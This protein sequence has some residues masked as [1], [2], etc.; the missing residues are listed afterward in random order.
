M[1]DLDARDIPYYW[2]TTFFR[3]LLKKGVRHVVI[4]PGSRSTP[5]TM[6]AAAHPNLEKHVILDE[7]SAAFTALGIGKAT[8]YPAVLICTSGTA[9]ANYYPAVIEAR[10]SGVP[11]ILATADRPPHL[12]ATGANQAIDQ[13]KLF[14]SYPV[15]F[16]EAGEPRLDKEDLDRLVLLA[17]QAVGMAQQKRGPVHINFPFRKPLEPRPSF[18]A[19]IRG[20]N[21]SEPLTDQE[22]R[23]SKS[24]FTL[25]ETVRRAMSSA[26][27]PLIVVGPAAPGDHLESV[28]HLAEQLRA[29]VLSESTIAS[30]NTVGGFA[31]FLR[32][33]QLVHQLE[34]DLILRFGFQPTAKSIE[35]ALQSWRPSHHIHFASTAD[36]QDATCTQSTH[37]PW[38]GQPLAL[39]D[40]LKGAPSS[41]LKTWK[42]QERLFRS[43]YQKVMSRPSVLTDGH[44][45]QHLIT[46]CPEDLFIAVSNSFPARDIQLTG[47]D[48]TRY[49]LYLNRGASGIDGV[50]STALG[51]S[52][53]LR[54]PGM[55]LTGDLAFLHDTNALLNHN[56]AGADLA[57]V[58][59]NNSG[60][61]IFR[62][63]PIEQH[64]AYFDTYF[65]TPQAASIRQL[66]NAYSIPYHRVSSVDELRQF[67][68]EQWQQEQPGLSVVECL[69]DAEASMK[70]RRQLWDF[71]P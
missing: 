35:Q 37:L 67:D 6:A 63:L 31:S 49:P 60:G 64:D 5:L 27:R 11:M 25:P 44:L 65:E 23:Y 14:G 28:A 66:A 10:Q 59:A 30:P 17:R 33:E 16:H 55:L 52:I 29:P 45:Y 1:T 69:T 32:N 19:K 70:L 61:S 4:S 51:I 39:P 38:L 2:S 56:R 13:L 20:E 53:G 26:D 36:W 47:Y 34:P 40:R 7:R 57:V 22:E 24:S 12:R 71:Q 43:H 9:A 15:F 54:K 68:L 3:Q 8:G 62:M 50:S 46:Q 58:I 21:S 18:V 42:R 41:W 48:I